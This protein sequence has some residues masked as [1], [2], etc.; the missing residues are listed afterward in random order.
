MNVNEDFFKLTTVQSV[1]SRRLLKRGGKTAGGKIHLAGKL[2][3]IMRPDP[4][5]HFGAGR[6][7]ISCQINKGYRL[8]IGR[9][10]KV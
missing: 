4:D 3:S 10:I 1:I 6:F 9:I 8:N 5:G 7:I 2:L